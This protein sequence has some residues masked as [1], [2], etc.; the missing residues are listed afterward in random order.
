MKSAMLNLYL[1][2][3]KPSSQKP[4]GVGEKIEKL[5]GAAFWAGTVAGVLGI[6]ITGIMMAV[7]LKRGESSEHV[8][9]LGM[10]LC[11]CCLIAAS[12]TFAGWLF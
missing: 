2:V 10:V 8:S 6:I 5:L 4:A 1:A 7:S 9:R 12:G 11:G 3:P